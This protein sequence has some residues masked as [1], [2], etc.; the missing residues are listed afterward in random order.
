ML[1]I[2]LNLVVV[3]ANTELIN[4]AYMKPT[5]MV[6]VYQNKVTEYDPLNAVDGS[7]SGRL[8]SSSCAATSAVKNAWWQVD[9]QA[10][11]LIKEVV[12]TNRGDNYGELEC[13]DDRLYFGK[14]SAGI[15]RI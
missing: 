11:H 2:K 4:L 13:V 15:V 10:I 5:K 8:Y 14:L 7:R 9:L 1:N 6:S 12:I 3:T